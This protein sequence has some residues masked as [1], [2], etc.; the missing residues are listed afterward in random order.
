MDSTSPTAPESRRKAN[1]WQ[2]WYDRQIWRGPNGLRYV[3]LARDPICR[4]CNRNASTVA[5]HIKPHKGV[6]ELFC[7][8][9]NLQGICEK[10]HALKTAKEDG[11][12]GN[13]TFTGARPET[14]AA[15]T[16]GD[17]GKQFQSSTISTKKLDKA[18]EG[19]EDLLNDIPE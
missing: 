19:I 12:F 10:C 15:V 4:I 18:L 8:L 11:G 13:K 3:T 9:A 2:K 7:D 14:N 16:T 17:S 5:D 1:P 6:W